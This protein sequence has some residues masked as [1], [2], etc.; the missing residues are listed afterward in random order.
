MKPTC[1]SQNANS[2]YPH[3]TQVPLTRRA[4]WALPVG[5]FRVPEIWKLGILVL[6]GMS[7][8]CG[9]PH[10]EFAEVQGTVTLNNKPLAGALV[11]FYPISAGKEQL[12]YASGMTDAVGLYML[13]H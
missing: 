12:P 9:G 2:Q 8:S 3:G 5:L 4:L 1:I 13:T 10:L 6:S 7:A 11:R